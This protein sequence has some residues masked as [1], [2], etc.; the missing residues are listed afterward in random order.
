VSFL[1]ENTRAP[2][3]EAASFLF[4]H[5]LRRITA[6]DGE[7]LLDSLVELEGERRLGRYLC[8]YLAYEAGYVLAH[9]GRVA[10]RSRSDR[11]MPLLD[12][13]TFDRRAALS[14]PE[15][16]RWLGRFESVA[17]AAVYDIR[18]SETPESYG[19]KVEA[20]QQMIAAGE[21][22]QVNLTMRLEFSIQASVRALY[23]RLRTRQRVEFGAF[24]RLPELEIASFSPELFLRKEGESLRSTPMKGT[25]RRGK[26]S[27]EDARLVSLLAS[28]PKTLSENVMIV[29]LIRSDLGRICETG[30]VKVDSL[31]D[32][33]TFETLHQMVSSVSGRVDR[34]LS[35]GYVLSAL[36]PCGSITG[37]PKIR[38]MDIIGDL[39]G[40]PR[41]L[42]TGALGFV[43][44][45]NDLC[46]SVPI[47]TIVARGT[48]AEMG[49]GSGIVAESDAGREYDE[50]LLKAYFLTGINASFGLIETMR[51]DAGAGEPIRLDAHLDRMEHSARCFGFRFDRIRVRNEATRAIARLL[52]GTFKVRLVLGQSGDIDISAV[53][54]LPPVCPSKLPWVGLST[55]RVDSTCCF[56][57]HKTTVR[58]LYDD[59]FAA[60]QARG[61]YDVI[62]VNERGEVA[63][64]SRHSVFA[65]IDGHWVTPPLTSGA[66]AGIERGSW[67]DER[68]SSATEAVLTPAVLRSARRVILTNAVRGRVEVSYVERDVNISSVP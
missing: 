53:P 25:E 31:F 64:A 29:D 43:T 49:I 16:T 14:G 32:V 41:G 7:T 24:I 11:E 44:P 9:T 15:V 13:F 63:E 55:H 67:L 38:T 37:A 42:Y 20:V 62:F 58:K 54:L 50:C 23:A 27:A 34:E 39:E 17:P 59:E 52:P 28:D 40:E 2:A 5:P 46:F 4:E 3:S 8:G 56:Q 57:H 22:Y 61:A 1:F 66:L 19:A 6:H 65:E 51:V 12:F 33:Q 30:S 26:S 10:P 36:F 60:W 45:E 48:R 35:L 18:C 47:R 68:K 21:T